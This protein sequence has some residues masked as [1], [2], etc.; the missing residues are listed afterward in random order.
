M[1]RTILIPALLVLVLM[2]STAVA[3]E[4][5]GFA[6]IEDRDLESI[7]T[8]LVT[9]ARRIGAIL[10]TLSLLEHSLHEISGGSTSAQERAIRE[11]RLRGCVLGSVMLIAGPSIVEE[12]LVGA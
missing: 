11:A 12:M 7:A 5:I 8:S 6:T 2:T 9:L 10:L 3:E 4:E 1:Y